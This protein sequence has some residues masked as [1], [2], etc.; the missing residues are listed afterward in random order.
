[1]NVRREALGLEPARGLV[2]LVLGGALLGVPHGLTPGAGLLGSTLDELVV[3][4]RT[5]TRCDT[6]SGG[7]VLRCSCHCLILTLGW[8]VSGC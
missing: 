1:M 2:L 3:V 8:A 4:S 7:F 6:G 5:A